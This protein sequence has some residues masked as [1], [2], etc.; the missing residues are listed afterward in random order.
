MK[1]SPAALVLRNEIQRRQ[2]VSNQLLEALDVAAQR[3]YSDEDTPDPLTMS[4][5]NNAHSI[6]L[7]YL[8]HTQRDRVNNL[9]A[10][11]KQKK[12]GVSTKAAEAARSKRQFTEQDVSPEEKN[13]LMKEVQIFTS[14]HPYYHKSAENRAALLQ[15]LY[16]NKL[17]ISARNMAEA[18][19]ILASRGAITVQD[20]ESL[21]TGRALSESPFLDRYVAEGKVR[22]PEELEAERVRNQTSDEYLKT[23]PEAQIAKPVPSYI[24]ELRWARDW[25]TF[26]AKHAEIDFNDDSTQDAI[27]QV[28]VDAKLPMGA[29]NSFQYAYEKMV[30]DGYEFARRTDETIPSPV[31]PVR[32][33]EPASAKRFSK[34]DLRKMTS[35]ELAQAYLDYPDLQ[36]QID[37]M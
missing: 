26:Q 12:S 22:T 32:I 13:Q 31:R 36:R 11:D 34:S 3:D 6:V 23:H 4:L 5:L 7:N 20:D 29:L 8:D 35:Q 30:A 14:T 9:I 25:K 37:L 15:Y 21:I 27:V 16:D 18:F 28:I 24:Q 10:L 17:S 1:L 19:S 2:L 33:A